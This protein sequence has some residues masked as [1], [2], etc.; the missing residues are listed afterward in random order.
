MKFKIYRVTTIGKQLDELF[1]K[2]VSCRKEAI[3]LIEEL[4]AKE[5]CDASGPFTLAGGIHG[6]RFPE[7]PKGWKLIAPKQFN[8][9]Y[10]PMDNNA[11]R[12]LLS[13]IKRLPT[14]MY[15]ELNNILGFEEQEYPNPHGRGMVMCTHPYINTKGNVYLMSISE[16]ARYTPKSSAIIE[17]TVSE[18]KELLNEGESKETA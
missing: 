12:E 17:I 8:D 14:V 18:Y 9:V 16:E 10:F 7:K 5:F 15:D 13:R 11:N 1:D 4:G 6:I 3:N 2:M